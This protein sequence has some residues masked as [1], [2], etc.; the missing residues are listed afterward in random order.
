M[1]DA[2]GLILIRWT[3][4]LAV[5]CYALRIWLDV[6]D[7]AS[8]RTRRA[9]WTV[10]AAFYF[11][12]VIAA[13]QFVHDW[14]HAD[15]WRATAEETA[16]VVGW[17]SGAGLWMNYAFT[18]LW[19]VDV[20]AWWTVGADYSRRFRRTSLAVQAAFAFLMFNATAVFGPA[21]WRPAVAAFA[22]LLAGGLLH[23]V[24]R[25]SRS[26]EPSRSSQPRPSA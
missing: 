14:S 6:A 7:G 18:L 15:A 22:L 8:F 4:R 26:R 20:G 13:F 11:A 23:Q 24:R 3:V 5:G 17:R 25:R 19:L 21:H 9:I 10:G 12:H 1:S 16:Q 2:A